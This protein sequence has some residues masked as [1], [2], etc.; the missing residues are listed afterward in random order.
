MK[1]VM[2]MKTTKAKHKE[3]NGNRGRKKSYIAAAVAPTLLL[4]VM[5]AAA[6]PPIAAEFY[7]TVEIDG[8][9]AEPGTNITAYDPNGIVCGRHTTTAA[10]EFGLLSCNGDDPTTPEDEGAT[11][12]EIV[13]IRVNKIPVYNA[14]W[15]EGELN[16]VRLQVNTQKA[17]KLESLA[18]PAAVIIPGIV[19]IL[20][21]ATYVYIRKGA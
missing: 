1:R 11:N 15:R 14:T 4:F 5:A 13:T 17:L 3:N 12:G 9:P 10:G 2:Q 8:K 6:L 7:G 18:L 16:K 20:A 19:L 21:V